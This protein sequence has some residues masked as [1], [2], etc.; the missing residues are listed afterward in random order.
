MVSKI[1][2]SLMDYSFT[3]LEILF[4]QGSLLRWQI[5]QNP[6]TGFWFVSFTTRR[7]PNTPSYLLDS[8]RKH[9][10]EFKSINSALK[11]VRYLGFTVERISSC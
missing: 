9:R 7:N 11:L 2:Q 5:E 6:I 3:E 10:K 1:L 8:R 4:D